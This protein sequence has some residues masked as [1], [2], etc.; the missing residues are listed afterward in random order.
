MENC[1]EAIEL[2]ARSQ[3]AGTR[4]S[5]LVEAVP[6]PFKRS[7]LCERSTDCGLAI[8]AAVLGNDGNEPQI[9]RQSAVTVIA[10][11]F[12]ALLIYPIPES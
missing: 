4:F 10:Y 6:E 8:I 2:K 3:P 11:S 12:T 5:P 7:L 9:T 1:D